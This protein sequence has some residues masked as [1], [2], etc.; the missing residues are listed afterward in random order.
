MEIKTEGYTNSRVS[1]IESK[2]WSG[3][4]P[5][6]GLKLHFVDGTSSPWIESELAKGR[7][8]DQEYYAVDTSKPIRKVAVKLTI[9]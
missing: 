3:Y 8:M 5:L 2:N 1:A 6:A 9:G 4:H 7:G